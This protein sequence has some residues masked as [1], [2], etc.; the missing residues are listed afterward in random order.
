MSSQVRV[1]DPK[2]RLLPTPTAP[3]PSAPLTR[4]VKKLSPQ[5]PGAR[6]WAATYGEKLVC[7]RYR[8]D[9][10][11]QRRQTTVEIVVDEAPTLNGLRVGVRVAW[12]E[13]DLGRAVRAAGGIWDATAKL[14]VMTLGQA[15]GLGLMDRI[16]MGP[17]P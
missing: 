17:A 9:L 3:T 8:V 14:W 1:Q 16:A 5:S 7:V 11:G 12:G 10:Q 13:K 2:G 4:V 6:R 15:K